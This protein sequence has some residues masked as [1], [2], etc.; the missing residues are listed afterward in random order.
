M[1]KVLEYRTKF[2]INCPYH[3]D[4]SSTEIINNAYKTISDFYNQTNVIEDEAK[5]L[6]NLETLFDL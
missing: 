5:D 2:Q 6:N 1:K 4:T 3:I